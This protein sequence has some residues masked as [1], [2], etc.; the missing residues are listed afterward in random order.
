MCGIAGLFYNDGAPPGAAELSHRMIHTLQ[1]RGPDGYGF[2]DD[3][4]VALAHARLSI[5]DL[6]TGDQPIH[7]EDKTVWVVFNGEIFNYIELRRELEAAGHRFYTNS[8]TEVIVHLYEQFGDRYMEHLNGQFAIALWDTRR[9]RLLL[10]RDRAGI[11]PLFYAQVD[12][13]LAFGSEIKSILA[14]PSAHRA[15]DMRAIGQIFT[16]WSTVPP[17]TAFE[18][19]STL[20]PGCTLIAD[21]GGQ[22]IERYWDWS[23]PETVP[24]QSLNVASLAEELRELLIDS[25]R[26][27]LRA[28]VPVGAYLSGGLDSSV[29]AVLI[30]RFTDTPLRTFSVEFEDAEFDES[31]Y[32]NEMVGHL[33]S[34]HTRVM[35]R[36]G[37]I[38]AVFPRLIA[39]VETPV[40]RTAPAPLMILAEHVRSQRFKVVLTGEGADE[41]FGGYDLFKEAKI[42]RFWARS[43]ESA[44]RP[45]LLSRL[46]GYLQHSPTAG[47]A[48][49]KQFFGQGLDMANDPA[50]AHMARWKSTQRLWQ[51]FSEDAQAAAGQLDPRAAIAATL[52]SEFD[53]W[54]PIGRDQYI[55]AHTLLAGYLL[56]SQGDRVAMAHSVEGRFPFLDHRVIEFASRLHPEMKIRGLN[57]KFLLKRAMRDLLPRGIVNRVKQ[58]YRA[59]DS[60]SFMSG[61]RAPDYVRD[62]MS[63]QSISSRGY[64]NPQ[65]VAR[66]VKKCESGRAIGFVDNMAFT[67]ILSTMLLDDIYIR[68]RGLD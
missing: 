1:H 66:L 51:F 4:Y 2:Y 17:A 45:K 24:S 8:D 50:F 52:P 64:F 54:L 25:V 39:Q 49:S 19:V 16:F 62:L 7:N 53:S 41:V 3:S 30:R 42:R 32:Q 37:D 29:I 36:K 55:E 5:I 67:G 47:G 21:E 46:Y 11:R 22:R 35:C 9:K 27:Q 59:P 13:A 28:D 65:A 26:L 60:Q 40:L 44:W 68:G 56:S 12:G 48:F 14:L 33:G 43:P 23:F 61:G 15:L 58:P 63:E 10:T 31:A 6:K 34:E 57:E 20:P 18:G 38:A